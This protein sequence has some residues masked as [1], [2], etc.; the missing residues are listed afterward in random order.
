MGDD[1]KED[2]ID[3][4]NLIAERY[5]LLQKLPEEI[6]EREQFSQERDEFLAASIGFDD[7]A[8]LKDAFAKV[9]PVPKM[10]FEL[11]IQKTYNTDLVAVTCIHII[12]TCL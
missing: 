6:G 12:S 2:A 10:W 11:I 7:M 8:Q 9:G 1:A 3:I 4:H 5:E